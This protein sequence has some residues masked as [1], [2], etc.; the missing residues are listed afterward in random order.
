MKAWPLSWFGEFDQWI[1]GKGRGEG[2]C[3]KRKDVLSPVLKTP[4]TSLP[5]PASRDDDTRHHESHKHQDLRDTQRALDLGIRP[6]TENVDSSQ[7]EYEH[8]DQRDLGHIR[9]PE[10]LDQDDDGD[11]E[12][13]DEHEVDVVVPPHGEAPR[14]RDEP[15]REVVEGAL[16]GEAGGQLAQG[17]HG[18]P[19][20]QADDGEGEEEAAGP[21]LLQALGAGYEEARADGAAQGHEDELP[22]GDLLLEACVLL[23]W[24]RGGRIWTGVGAG[25]GAGPRGGY[26]LDLLAYCDGGHVIVAARG[27]CCAAVE[28]EHRAHRGRLGRHGVDAWKAG[29]AGWIEEGVRPGETLVIWWICCEVVEE[30]GGGMPG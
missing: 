14:R 19:D 11:L 25:A 9:A 21:A 7:A 28:F 20:G 12:R 10:A 18:E 22:G 3:Y 17:A 24:I 15:H 29:K 6:S 1:V 4:T 23:S 16:H 26:Y 5:R 27:R 8:R 30:V 2:E 13:H